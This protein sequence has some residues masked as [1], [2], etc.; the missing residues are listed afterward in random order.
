MVPAATLSKVTG[1][2][3]AP[4]SVTF[5]DGVMPFAVAGVPDVEYCN[6]APDC[7]AVNALP[8]SV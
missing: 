6:G 8:T 1:P 4:T 2:A 7:I 3:A 5:C